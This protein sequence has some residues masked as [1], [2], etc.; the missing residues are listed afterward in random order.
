MEW[1]RRREAQAAFQRKLI[2]RRE[3]AQ[4]LASLG[5]ESLQGE[6]GGVAPLVFFHLPIKMQSLPGF[7]ELKAV[8][9]DMEKREKEA[10]SLDF[11][12]ASSA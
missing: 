8:S 5:D 11:P 1:E 12:A 2:E 3:T 9:E 7:E 6:E 10:R 4:T